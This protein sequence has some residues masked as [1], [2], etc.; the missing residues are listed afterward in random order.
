MNTIATVTPTTPT[1]TAAIPETI[2]DK[3]WDGLLGLICSSSLPFGLNGPDATDEERGGMFG[4]SEDGAWPQHV[5]IL[6]NDG[7]MC[8]LSLSE[9]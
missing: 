4:G 7:K 9:V 6:M 3:F 5:D 8:R 2:A 1:P